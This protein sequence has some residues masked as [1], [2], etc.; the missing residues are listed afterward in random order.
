MVKNPSST[1]S[2]MS[3]LENRYTEN[4]FVIK[5]SSSAVTAGTY[6][7]RVTNNGSALNSY[8]KYAVLTLAG[9]TNIA[10]AFTT[11]PSDSGSASTAPTNYGANVTFRGTATDTDSNDYYLAI[12]KTN[13]ITAG[14]DGPPTC[15]AGSWCVSSAAS[16]SVEATCQY[17]AADPSESLD[18]Y[19]F[20]CD[21][22]A[23]FSIAKCSAMSQG[24]G[25]ILNN[26]PFAI[27]HPPIYSSITTSVDNQNPGGSFTI[28]TVSSDTDVAGGTDTLRLHICV[29]NSAS[30]A[31]CAS[32]TICTVTSTSSPNAKCYFT[33]TAPTPSGATTYYGFM[34]DSH[35]LAAT[36]NSRSS[37]YTI[38]NTPPSLGALVLNNNAA[39][40]LNI[41]GAGDKQVQI[42]N[43]S[44]TDLNG[45]TNLISSVGRIYMTEYDYNC[46]A[47]NNNC[48]QISTV[49][50]I[51]T[52]CDSA[53]DDTATYTCTANLKYYTSPTDN[54][55]GNP[56][57]SYKWQ[58]YIQ[59]YDGLNYAATTSPQ[60]ELNTSIA[61]DVPE[62]NID[63]GSTLFVGENTGTDNEIT[64]IVNAGNSP[65]NSN[66][67][68]TDLTAVPTGLIAVNYIKYS[69]T[70]GFN[71][72]T[73]TDLTNLQ[74][75]VPITAPKAT[76]SVDVLDYIYW[77]IG[78]PY[79]SGASLYSGTNTFEAAIDSSE[80]N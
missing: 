9:N 22:R 80:W 4:E 32:T 12:C 37:T 64:T 42:V 17:Q 7:F 56:K 75:N 26:S 34:Y 40:T 8:S 41:K 72:P 6:C 71:Y 50:C 43:T 54:S 28:S 2:P 39:I 16:T 33:D 44:V 74:V 77:G 57:E 35:G 15:T 70:S 21:K 18:W 52:A 27:N 29:T 58:G 36:D 68:G 61:L 67:A 73:G 78:I 69:L 63:F 59:V 53:D 19:G 1:T 60:V 11:F 23:G 10:P 31:G 30:F 76:S 20:A 14:N 47:N 79:G 45:C 49:S 13:A 48:Y 51:K 65:L 24:N 38:N 5:A 66:I 46:S 3:L 55:S 62:A 25:G